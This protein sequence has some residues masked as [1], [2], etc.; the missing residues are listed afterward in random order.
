MTSD[1]DPVLSHQRELV[2]E[3]VGAAAEQQLAS[4]AGSSR[5]GA[6][7]T[8]ASTGRSARAGTKRPSSCRPTV[9]NGRSC[10]AAARRAASSWSSTQATKSSPDQPGRS[11]RSSGTLVGRPRRRWPRSARRTGASRRPRRRTTA[12]PSRSPATPPKPPIRTSPTGQ[13]GPGHPAGQRGG[14]VVAVARPAPRPA[15]GPRRCRRAAAPSSPTP[16]RA[17]AGSEQRV[18]VEVLLDQVAEQ[19]EPALAGGRERRRADVTPSASERYAA[20]CASS[21]S[22]AVHHR[23]G[24]RAGRSASR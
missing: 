7:T 5:S 14:H 3:P 17:P 11:S 6:S 21:S 18:D 24:H 23:P 10:S 16:S 8:R 12:R 1:V 9:R 13:P 2:L 19:V 22:D 4:D 15:R 20:R